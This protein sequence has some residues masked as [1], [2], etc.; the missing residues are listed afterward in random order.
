MG[1]RE[2]RKRQR[3]KRGQEVTK[4]GEGVHLH[5]NSFLL[6]TCEALSPVILHS[7][8]SFRVLNWG[9]LQFLQEEM[10]RIKARLSIAAVNN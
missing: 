4:K 8:I 2:N 7:D 5:K 3:K 10:Y 6:S 9:I 1:W